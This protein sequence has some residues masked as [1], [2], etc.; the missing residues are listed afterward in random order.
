M[1]FLDIIWLKDVEIVVT[2]DIKILTIISYSHLESLVNVNICKLVH[3]NIVHTYAYS[4]PS[5][6]ACI[7]LLLA[8]E[9][10]PRDIQVQTSKSQGPNTDVHSC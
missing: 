10:V 3:I 1:L 4:M 7:Y 6:P 9:C 8:I 5:T 2:P